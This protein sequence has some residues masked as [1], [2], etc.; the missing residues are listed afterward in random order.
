MTDHGLFVPIHGVME[1]LHSEHPIDGRRYL[2]GKSEDGALVTFPIDVD[3][4]RDCELTFLTGPQD[5]PM[6]ENPRARAILAGF[7]GLHMK[8]TGPAI[9]LGLTHARVHEVLVQID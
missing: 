9:F 6:P 4:E 3:G 8:V 7:T 5:G 1:V 2:R